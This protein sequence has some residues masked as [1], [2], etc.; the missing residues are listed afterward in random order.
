MW[1][2]LQFFHPTCCGHISR[3]TLQL[4]LFAAIGY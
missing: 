4:L 2:A 3:L 1:K